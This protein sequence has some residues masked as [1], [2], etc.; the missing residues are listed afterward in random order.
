MGAAVPALW[1]LRGRFFGACEAHALCAGRATRPRASNLWRL[2]VRRAGR[3]S[4]AR[5]A[6]QFEV[7]ERA[8]Q[9]AARAVSTGTLG[10]ARAGGTRRAQRIRRPLRSKSGATPNSSPARWPTAVVAGHSPAPDQPAAAA[11][12]PP[13][14]APRPAA[15]EPADDRPAG[16][17]AATAAGR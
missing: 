7:G 3:R 14:A 5:A 15:A 11:P 8:G 2:T 17:I 13:P 4:R 9:L 1:C 16:R 12:A 6:N 10:R